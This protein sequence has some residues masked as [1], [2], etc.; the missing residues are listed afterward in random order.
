MLTA[1]WPIS[2]AMLLIAGLGPAHAQ[3]VGDFDLLIQDTRGGETFRITDTLGYGEF[4]A[5]FSPNGDTLVHEVIEDAPPFSAFL[6]LTD[7]ASGISVPLPGGEGGNDAAYSPN[8]Q[9]IAFD[10]LN[11][12][13]PSIY[14]LPASGGSPTLLRQLALAPTWSNNSRRIAFLDFTDGSLRTI[15]VETGEETNLGEAGAFGDFPDWSPNGK[16][17]AYQTFGGNL[18]AIRVNEHGQPLGEPIIVTFGSFFDGSPSWSN[19]SKTIVFNSDRDSVWVDLWTVNIREVQPPPECGVED[20]GNDPAEAYGVPVFLRG[21]MNDWAANDAS[22]FV[23]QGNGIYE[24]EVLL[25][26]GGSF[27]KVASADWVAADFAPVDP[28]ELDVP[29]VMVPAPGGIPTG[30]IDVALAGCYRF[31]MDASDTAA[32]VL[33]VNEVATTDLIGALATRLTGAPDSV[34]VDPAYS[35]NGRYVVYSGSGGSE[36]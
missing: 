5:G 28:V 8:G 32:P 7:V 16:W 19:N 23:N 20:T 13:D 33:V 11:A 27:F 14:L 22:M 2:A 1:S 18:R 35:N 26:D 15:D 21:S 24:V 17:I 36:P 3:D 34:E 29:Q 30:F 12:D 6:A 31:V 25:P 9:Y 4:N 10:R